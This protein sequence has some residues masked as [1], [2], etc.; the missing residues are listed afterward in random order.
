MLL[1]GRAEVVRI[2][3]APPGLGLR[4]VKI[5]DA[6]KKLIERIVE[7]N[8]REGKKPMVSLDFSAAGTGGQLKG[9]AGA[10]PVSG[11]IAWGDTS[12]SI[13]LNT[14]TLSYFVY[15]PLLNIRLG[16]FVVPADRDL[17]LGTIFDVSITNVTGDKLFVGKG[18][19]VAKHESRLGI[20]LTAED[21]TSL[22]R[23]QAEVTKLLPAQK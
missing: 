8:S 21:K 10:T 15:N 13:E 9:L 14:V 4:F 12:V 17:P 18:K 11:G 22:V 5:D 3:T 23:L 16:G 20:R 2:S 1:K 19:V 7:I 6:T